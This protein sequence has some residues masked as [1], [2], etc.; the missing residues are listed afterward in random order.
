M[1][2]K[3]QRIV[4]RLFSL[5]LKSALA[6]LLWATLILGYGRFVEPGWV[7]TSHNIVNLP[8]LKADPAVRI[9]QISDLHGQEFGT[10]GYLAEKVNRENP[11]LLVLT[12]DA[13]DGRFSDLGYLERNLAPM[14]AKYGKFFVF[15]NNEYSLMMPLEDYVKQLE[16][17]G[18]V[19]LKNRSVQM[20]IRGQ[21]F[22][23]VG[24]DDPN[25]GRPDLSSALKDA[26]AG[27]KILLAHSPEIIY[28][29]ARA[30]VDLVLAGHTHG[31]QIRLPGLG[32]L[33]TNVQPRFER[34][35]SGFYQVGGT[36]LYVNRGIGT[37]RLL[38]RMFAPPEIAVFDLKA[39][40]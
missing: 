14:K 3:L 5:T 33:A 16:K 31:G 15:G 26:G 40:E 24:V 37:T 17:A 29:A 39:G 21:K 18:F 34:F 27:P 11:D 19:I 22:R 38:F 23:L 32:N 35:V 6:G 9:V 25:Y 4:F 36:K 20:N 12:G 7:W 28:Q 1:F 2:R 10:P 8:G 30:G 13:L